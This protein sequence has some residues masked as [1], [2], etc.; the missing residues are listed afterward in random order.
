MRSVLLGDKLEVSAQGLGCMGMSAFY[1]PGNDEES[2]ATLNRAL[3]LGVTFW[4]TSDMYGPHTNERLLSRVLQ[5]RRDEVQLATKFGFLTNP[6]GTHGIRGDAAYVRAAVDGSLQRLGTDR[7]DLY[8]QHRQDPNTPIEESVGAMAELVKA[9]KV[10]HLG[11]SE[12]TGDELRRARAVHPIAAIQPEWS[13]WTRDIEAE[14]VPVARELGV[15]IVPYSPLGRG[16]L[17]GQLSDVD[18]LA[19][20]DF[21]RAAPR[22]AE[23][24]RQANVALIQTIEEIA[25]AHGAAK[26]QVALAWVH[27]RSEVHGLPVVPIP[28]TRRIKWLEQNVGGLDV[29][30]SAEE[31][32]TLDTIADRVAGARYPSMASTFNS[33][34]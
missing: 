16:F 30:L 23:E 10:L 29:A 4:D 8:Y 25:S 31:L 11:L 15:G 12:V 6:D 32:S 14:V 34:A 17:T 9:G 2:V 1:G 20:D 28:G 24:N 27:Q 21:R 5:D 3:E 7:I 19:P 33:R 26:A 18:D 13:L 22:F